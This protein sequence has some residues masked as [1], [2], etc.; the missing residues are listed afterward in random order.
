MQDLDRTKQPAL[1]IGGFGLAGLLLLAPLMSTAAHPGMFFDGIV[2]ATIARNMAVGDGDCWHPH[3]ERGSSNQWYEAPT[4]AIWLE[5]LCF[6][7]AGD[8][9]WV[10]KIY[11]VLTRL[12]TAALMV[13][14][15]RSLV[16]RDSATFD[17]GWLS[18]A[19]W[20]LVPALPSAY[21]NN[22]LENTLGV[23]AAASVY[24]SIRAMR[25]ERR[26]LIWIAAAAAALLGAVLAKGPVGLFPLVTPLLL[27]MTVTSSA[28]R[29][30]L[31]L[32][33]LLATAFLLLFGL[34]LLQPAAREY[35]VHYFQTQVIA[36]VRG[37]RELVASH[38]GRA[39]ILSHLAHQLTHPLIFA[40]ALVGLG[41]LGAGNWFRAR[42][43]GS[44]SDSPARLE[45]V[46]TA[47]PVV[48]FLL[49]TAMSASLPI[50]I[51]QKQ[52]GHYAIPSFPFFALAL[53]AWCA[54]S[55]TAIAKSL[56]SVNVFE[57]WSLA[58]LTAAAAVLI[59]VS[60]P[61]TQQSEAD[62]YHD[63]QA[64]VRALPPHSV[65]GFWPPEQIDFLL[66]A[67]LA[68]WSDAR[69][70]QNAADHEFR[71]LPVG[72]RLPP[73]GYCPVAA[74]LRRWQLCRRDSIPEKAERP[75][76]GNLRD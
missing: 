73:D 60:G 44:P 59:G 45:Q 28:R 58:P 9:A 72:S 18:V 40:A 76:R 25:S 55:M 41:R 26:T 17:Q 66:Y 67:N 69:V 4:G 20:A 50:M 6:R 10:E 53:A 33:C 32:T 14:I 31:T 1:A 36:S 30:S 38:L 16:P 37:Q 57:L 70:S 27:G 35:L 42:P 52:W 51:S 64:I 75:I 49:L 74:E 23:F 62:G 47:G 54:P 24:C 43:S 63:A 15:W 7:V 68:R 12:A 56:R 61:A 19:I 22:L 21:A 65:V 48:G 46:A 34:V 2:Y 3:W 39:Y 11:S 71:I 5:S 29:K 8:H 13:L